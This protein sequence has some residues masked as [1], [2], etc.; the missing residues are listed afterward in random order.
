ML[1]MNMNEV[2]ASAIDMKMLANNLTDVL[3]DCSGAGVDIKTE[4]INRFPLVNWLRSTSLTSRTRTKIDREGYCVF[5]KVDGQW[6]ID[7]PKSLW[8][9]IPSTTSTECCWVAPD[10]AS[11]GGNVP[12]NLL[13]LKDCENRLDAFIEERLRMGERGAVEGLSYASDSIMDVR[14]RYNRLFMAFLT[15]YTIILGEDNVSTNI[16]KP[17]HGLM[18]VM[19]NAAV[20][21]I[22]GTNVLA[23]FD[24]L[25]CRLAFLGGDEYV[26]A[27]N[28]IVYQTLLSV[29][30]ADQ[31]GMLPVGWTRNGDEIRFRGIRF[32][33]DRF[34]PVDLAD[35][36]GEAWLLNGDSTGLYLATD[37]MPSDRY[38]FI[39]EQHGLAKADGCASVCMYLYN[40]GAVLNNNA[41]R[42]AKIVNIPVTAACTST[43]ASMSG[44]IQPETLIPDFVLPNGE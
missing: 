11:C 22:D 36:V 24:E 37:L 10:L 31:Y 39:D 7:M 33:Q 35:G 2:T 27:I 16:L 9:E 13:C 15:A 42:L 23:A 44:L 14:T 4:L 5:H 41:N 30:R 28:P 1:D 18:D 12:I 40:Y 43:M 8:T 38:M 25:G 3:P 6:V 17:F 20:T 26:I 34:V 32:I 19:G 29:I 21:S